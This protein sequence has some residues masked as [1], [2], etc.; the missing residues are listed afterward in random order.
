MRDFINPAEAFEALM[1]TGDPV[2]IDVR[3]PEIVSASG[4]L[5]PATSYLADQMEHA[6]IAALLDRNRLIIVGCAHGHNRSQYFAA[7][8]RAAGFGAA[9]LRGG[10][11]AW[12][13][14]GMPVVARTA[15]QI[16]IG[17]PIALGA[18][19]TTWI[20]RRHPKIDRIACPWL[21]RRLLDPRAT[22]LFA[23]PDHVLAI[24]EQTG[25]IAYDLPGAALEHDGDLCTFDTILRAFGLADDPALA[26]LALIVRG[27]DTDRLTLHPACA[28][29]LGVSL[30]LSRLHGDDDHGL[31]KQGFGVY[32]G[33]YAWL[34]Q[35]R[36]ETH[37]W[38]RPKV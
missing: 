30:G 15:G 16:E 17:Q 32:D 13:E 4:V 18:A 6:A 5:F 38:P 20:T 23:D 27:G 10:M 22:F 33:L 26:E 1:G 37:S 29:L 31:L 19:P 24:A 2:L 14:A 21:I 28:G 9:I 34:R 3:K 12:Q 11:T 36:G 35:A 25:A 7:A 8:L